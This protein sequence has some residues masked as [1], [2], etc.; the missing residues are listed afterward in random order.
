MHFRAYAW[1]LL[2]ATL[3]VATAMRL[4]PTPPLETDLLAL[5]PA[6]E[7]NPLAEQ[8]ATRLGRLTGD[9][10]VFL[11]GLPNENNARRAATQLAEGLCKSDAFKHCLARIPSS[12]P[13]GLAALYQPYFNGLLA[14]SVRHEPASVEWFH[15]RL[16]ARLS[17]PLGPGLISLENDPFGLQERWLM[18]IPFNQLRLEV[19]DGW[20]QTHAEGIT[21]LLVSAELNGSAFDSGLQSTMQRSL[22]ASEDGLKH[23]WPELRLL[24]VGAVFHA[25]LARQNAEREMHWIG[26]ASLIGIVLLM[27]W[28]YRSPSPLVLALL[29][30]GMGLS[31]AVLVS[32]A[33]FDR[34]HLMTLVFGASL[35]GEAVDYALQYC[36]ARLGAGKSWDAKQGLRQVLPGLGVA[37]ATSVVGY[38]ALAFTPFPALH[39]ISVFAI[40][41]LV[42]AW[43]TV[44]LVLPDWLAHPSKPASSALLAWPARWLRLWHSVTLRSFLIVTAG[45]LLLAA[46]GWGQLKVDDDVRQLIKP[47]AELAAQ[48]QRFRALTGMGGGS[49]FF[50]IEGADAEQVLQRDESLL[51]HLTATGIRTQSVA[52]FVP[53][54]KAQAENRLHLQASIAAQ[55]EALHTA[56]FRESVISD[57]VAS[58]RENETCITPRQWLDSPLSTPFRHLWMEVPGHPPASL[59]IPTSHYEISQLE[60]ASAGLPGITLVDKPGAVSR[61]FGEYRRLASGTLAGATLL[62]LMVLALRYGFR[63]GVA[64]LLPV[65]L[66][67]ALTLG[68]LG[69]FG[70]ALNL[71]NLL[72][73]LLVL[74]VGINYSIFLIEGSRGEQPRQASAQLGVML[75]AAT[76]LLS[77]GLLGFSSMPALS[78]F[79]ITLALGIGL[80]VVLA[81]S[82]LL[83]G[84]KL[85]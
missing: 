61:L 71:F 25:S 56:G 75:S 60:N 82:T 77:F 36:S 64:I 69:W 18:E 53:S 11:V 26:S 74:G 38:T 28:A 17:S 84:A 49:Q 39:Q 37:L 21:W 54:C 31:T 29:S 12:D 68:W 66:A 47:P 63:S 9:R 1:L 42:A 40:S 70:I 2:A 27:A 24:R 43:L 59:I 14:A 85:R 76:T 34:L 44:L 65:L 15:E 58:V 72:A 19:V 7:R 16:I 48:E 51:L 45:L 23:H 30:V 35:I 50:L 81:P 22:N 10:A 4:L 46:F 13:A 55:R 52:R 83:L 78:G 41:G 79:G 80:A 67:Q 3:L 5:L 20:L 33:F 57:W 32:L 62:I 73:L 6:T 8:A